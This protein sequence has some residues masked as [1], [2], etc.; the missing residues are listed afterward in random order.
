MPVAVAEADQTP[1]AEADLSGI[2]AAVDTPDPDTLSPEQT[3]D[4]NDG[5]ADGLD[6]YEPR[7]TEL[8]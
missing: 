1:V 8:A 5:S 2:D 7:S 3:L 6:K 4:L